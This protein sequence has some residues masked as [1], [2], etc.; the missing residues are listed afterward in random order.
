M[1]ARERCG[2]VHALRWQREESL[3]IRGRIGRGA[4]VAFAHPMVG[5]GEREAVR[6]GEA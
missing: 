3:R 6:A 1:A 2:G 4:R 5:V